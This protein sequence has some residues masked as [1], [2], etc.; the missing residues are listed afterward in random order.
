[1]QNSARQSP[2]DYP[3]PGL[4]GTAQWRSRQ[5]CGTAMRLPVVSAHID[6][7]PPIGRQ[8]PAPAA[9]VV[10][11]IDER[12]SDEEAVVVPE[13]GVAADEGSA[14]PARAGKARPDRRMRETCAAE[15]GTADM[16]ETGATHAADVHAAKAARMHSATEM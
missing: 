16:G 11:G 1:M 2:S 4:S 12:C 15:G 7:L 8:A 9:I 13:E 3:I 5:W 10:A 14:V 6:P